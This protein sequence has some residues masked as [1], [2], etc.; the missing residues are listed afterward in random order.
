MPELL[1]TLISLADRLELPRDWLREEALA[2][3]IPCLHIRGRLRFNP[4]AVEQ[5]LARLA[6]TSRAAGREVAYG[7]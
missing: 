5:E 6:A 4:V 2:G 7:S 1:V 3:R